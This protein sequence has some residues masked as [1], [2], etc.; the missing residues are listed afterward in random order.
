MRPFRPLLLA[1]LSTCSLAPLDASAGC[2]LAL[3]T[4][5]DL[6]VTAYG[7]DRPGPL[8]GPSMG[9]S[10]VWTGDGY[11]V[12]YRHL[13]ERDQWIHLAR[14][15]RTPRRS[16]PDL[17]VSS[18]E[19]GGA[20]E[21]LP[22]LTWSGDAFAVAFNGG[23][24][25]FRV[26]RIGP[27]GV[28]L[29]SIEVLS[30]PDETQRTQGIALDWNGEGFGAAW[31]TWTGPLSTGR[32]MV[33][34]V[35]LDP[36]GSAPAP[37]PPEVDL[38]RSSCGISSADRCVASAW[39]GDVYGL[40]WE[41]DGVDGPDLFFARAD[42]AGVRLGPVVPLSTGAGAAHHP[43]VVWTGSAFAVAWDETD[44]GGI[45]QIV[46]ARL[47]AGGEPLDRPAPV[48]RQARGA[49]RPAL[50][51]SGAELGLFFEL[52][53]PAGTE[54]GFVRLD[55]SGRPAGP[56]ARP[57]PGA[58]GAFRPSAVW[59]GSGFAVAWDETR[60]SSR[61][62]EIYFAQLGCSRIDVRPGNPKNV[63]NLRSSG[64][65]P[66][67]I[68]GSATLDVTLVDPATVRFGPASA[69]AAFDPSTDLRDADGDGVTDLVLRFR[70]PETGI[71]CRDTTAVLTGKTRLG[72]EFE[73]VD[74]IATEGCR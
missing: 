23:I 33:T 7:D 3:K 2:E 46:L 10:L 22:S 74:A 11:G 67:A 28:P 61:G 45:P 51:W 20:N 34:L 17:P 69:P 18:V 6:Q 16:G 15:D 47:D 42:A 55:P 35:P 14:I 21:A 63:V 30:G 43:E 1:A 71:A 68:L 54:I 32:T 41:A 50:A 39:N 49:A 29:G 73:V 26:G 44:A 8:T 37:L 5:A 48:T 66:V 62:R 53:G 58:D 59:N 40:A 27:D 65:L 36:S 64:Q 4:N 25:S 12:A 70:I 24:D 9:A 19:S 38:A 52:G 56:V 57:T 72:Q 13:G 60:P 31:A